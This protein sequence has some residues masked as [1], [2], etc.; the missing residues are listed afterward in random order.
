MKY[1]F[2]A[3]WKHRI[4]ETEWKGFL[5][6]TFA[7]EAR[8]FIY[9][10]L[11]NYLSLRSKVP[12]AEIGFGQC[13]D[14]Q[15]C[16]KEL[17]DKGMI[18]YHGYDVT[19]QFT[20]YAG[21]TYPGYEFDTVNIL[22]DSSPQYDITY[23]RHVLEHQSPDKCYASFENLLKRTTELCIVTWFIGPDNEKFSWV[24]TDGFAQAGAFV[25]TLSFDRLNAI[26]EQERF[27]LEISQ[28]P[29]NTIYLLKKDARH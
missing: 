4:S 8:K 23:I 10:W 13:Y 24:P 5:D 17:H 7:D 27:D 26:I 22:E 11:N 9:Q 21:R 18:H 3:A 20:E 6:H 29:G 15:H 14:F 12:L 28:F 1:D 2:K 16:F 19:S 25:N